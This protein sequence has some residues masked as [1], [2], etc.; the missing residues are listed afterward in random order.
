MSSA[1]V[2]FMGQN[3]PLQLCINAYSSKETS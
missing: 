2:L 1:A 3:R